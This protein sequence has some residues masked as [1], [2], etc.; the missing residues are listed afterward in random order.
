ML[1]K[2]FRLPAAATAWTSH[3]IR[4]DSF[5]WRAGATGLLFGSSRS[6][7]LKRYVISIASDSQGS[8]ILLSARWGRCPAGDEC[9]PL[10]DQLL[11]IVFNHFLALKG[12]TLIRKKQCHLPRTSKVQKAFPQDRWL[13]LLEL[14]RREI[15]VSFLPHDPVGKISVWKHHKNGK[16]QHWPG[17]FQCYGSSY[18]YN[19]FIP[20]SCSQTIN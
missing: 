4:A 18:L 17:K 1:L 6:P 2:A 11:Q 10:G 5:C 15:V 19:T 14:N 9:D 3:T 7:R 12:K 16:L 20:F 8:L 13:M